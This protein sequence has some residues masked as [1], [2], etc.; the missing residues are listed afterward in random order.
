M[1]ISYELV[2]KHILKVHTPKCL[3]VKMSYQMFSDTPVW[4]FRYVGLI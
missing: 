2:D 3:S 4:Q 1:Y